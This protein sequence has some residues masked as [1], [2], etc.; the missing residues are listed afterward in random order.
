YPCLLHVTPLMAIY[1]LSL[2][3]ALPIFKESKNGFGS[4]QISNNG[5]YANYADLWLKMLAYNIYIL[6]GLEI[7]QSTHKRYT[8]ARF[9]RKFLMI[10]ARLVTH[11]RR[12][13]LKLSNTFNHF[14]EWL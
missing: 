13:N 11:A 5:F 1:T 9:R 4:D 14:S 3:D 2:L 10:P 7:C 12:T 6:F 8:I